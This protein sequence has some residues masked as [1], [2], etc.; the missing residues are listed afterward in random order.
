MFYKGKELKINPGSSLFYT[1]SLHSNN[2][3]RF[4]FTMQRIPNHPLHLSDFRSI[5]AI[6]I[7]YLKFCNRLL[8]EI[9]WSSCFHFCPCTSSFHRGSHTSLLQNKMHSSTLLNTLQEVYISPR[10]TANVVAVAEM[11]LPGLGLSTWLA[12]SAASVLPLSSSH[13]CP[14][15]TP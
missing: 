12:S 11:T 8:I 6:C 13:S 3:F 14:F 4:T 1:P 10:V 9:L 5:S 2:L 7:S 15:G